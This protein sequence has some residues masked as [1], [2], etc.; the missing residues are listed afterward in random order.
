MFADHKRYL[1][2][3]R[4]GPLLERHDLASL[5][6]LA[7]V[8]A[9]NV[10]LR[11]DV[12]HQMTTHETFFFR[13]TPQFSALASKILPEVV[14]RVAERKRSGG[15][16]GAAIWSAACSTGQEPY[17]LA[18]LLQE[19][20][21]KRADLGVR[22][23]DVEILGT[24]ISEEVLKRAKKGWYSKLEVGRGMNT[25]RT[26]AYFRSENGGFQVCE[27]I[28]QRVSFRMM[29]ITRPFG[30]IGRFDLVL[31]RNVLIYFSQE[32]ARR[33]IDRI[34]TTQETGA[35][36]MLG[37]SESI[38]PQHDAYEEIKAAGLTIYRRK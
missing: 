31:C 29:N 13:D 33:A 18:M 14:S 23:E 32:T 12:I 37:A 10:A 8:V 1:F 16:S 38:Y 19:L 27:K 24:D 5:S 36:L 35:Y 26:G 30:A 34:A 17:S 25:A 2:A 20:C 3:Q 21:P 11:R 7:C 4:L 6:E 15:R 22:P 28:Q 9:G